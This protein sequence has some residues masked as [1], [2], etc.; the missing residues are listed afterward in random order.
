M[1]EWRY[2]GVRDG[3]RRVRVTLQRRIILQVSV[4]P[5]VVQRTRLDRVARIDVG[6]CT[7][8]QPIEAE[9]VGIESDQNR[10]NQIMT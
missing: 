5:V 2:E 4:P 7:R 8:R 6:P 1:H 10:N 9:G 3:H